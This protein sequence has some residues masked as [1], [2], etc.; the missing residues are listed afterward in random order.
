MVWVKQNFR[1]KRNQFQKNFA[2]TKIKAPKNMGPKSLVS[3]ICD[4]HN[5]EKDVPKNLLLK[6]GQNQ[7]GNS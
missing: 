4:I 6:S 1:Q 5:M 3:N 7:V 2:P